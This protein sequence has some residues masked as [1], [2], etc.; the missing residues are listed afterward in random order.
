MHK[1]M[2]NRSCLPSNSSSKPSRDPCRSTGK[3][4]GFACF[5]PGCLRGETASCDLWVSLFQVFLL[6]LLTFV[7]KARAEKRGANAVTLCVCGLRARGAG[8]RKRA[9]ERVLSRAGP[10][11]LHL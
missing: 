6:L 1:N 11:F 2:E 5:H 9:C 8:R 4:D 3:N 10:P 7:C